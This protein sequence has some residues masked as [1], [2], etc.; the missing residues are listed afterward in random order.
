M[1]H[2]KVEHSACQSAMQMVVRRVQLR[3]LRLDQTKGA[4]SE[5]WMVG[6]MARSSAAQSDVSMVFEKAD[7][8]GCW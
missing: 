1:A 4:R 8:S 6:K 7:H 5:N 2:K 3:V